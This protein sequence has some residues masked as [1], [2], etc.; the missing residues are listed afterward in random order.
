MISRS[1]RFLAAPIAHALRALL[2]L[3]LVSSAVQATAPIQQ[4]TNPAAFDNLYSVVD[5]V[6]SRT[7][8]IGTGSIIDKHINVNGIGFFCVLTADHNFPDAK[9]IGFGDWGTAP[10]PANGFASVY[11]V[12]ALGT[13]GS[14]GTKDIAVAIVRYGAVDAFFNGVEELDLWSPPA[15]NDAALAVHTNAN[16]NKF[17]EVGFG[18]TG[19]PHYAMG[20]QDGFTPQDS[21]GTQRFQNANRTSVN[22][23][24]AHGAYTYT[25][26]RWFPQPVSPGNPDLGGGSSFQGD[27][28]G[29]YFLTDEV[30]KTI[31]GLTDVF[32]NA[33]GNQNIDLF[34]NTIFA[35]H[36]FGNNKNP[37]LFSD[38]STT[39]PHGGVLLSAGDVEWIHEI[40]HIPEPGTAVLLIIM[41][42]SWCAAT[43][44]PFAPRR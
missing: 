11:P 34:T 8:D 5:M 12:V 43:R 27:S 23:N 39:D 3:V 2:F 30:T 32:G 9:A 13:G 17:T 37:Q 42:C 1:T 10:N 33:V 15:G 25:D 29:P 44:R 41:A 14:T 38:S 18:N 7:A 20:V 22:L 4:R 36:T 26:V 40:C 6:A 28:G 35:V 19:V 21:F 31:A 16:V 24:A